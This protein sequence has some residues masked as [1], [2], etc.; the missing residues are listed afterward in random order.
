MCRTLEREEERRRET[1]RQTDRE[2]R[3]YDDDN[4]ILCG[5]EYTRMA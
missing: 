4:F 2:K 1:D 3:E 5:K